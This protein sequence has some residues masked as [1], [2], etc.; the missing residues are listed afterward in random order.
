MWFEM[1][2]V[3]LLMMM[4]LSTSSH[5]QFNSN[6]LLAHKRSCQTYGSYSS[7]NMCYLTYS[8]IFLGIWVINPC[9]KFNRTSM[10]KVI[11]ETN[12]KCS[13]VMLIM[14]RYDYI[15]VIFEDTSA[16]RNQNMINHRKQGV[17]CDWHT[18]SRHQCRETF[19]IILN[20][21]YAL[22]FK[23]SLVCQHHPRQDTSPD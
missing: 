11:L 19:E 14:L 17:L 15:C 13:Y 4:I 5:I 2:K 7:V 23:V 22:W 12:A 10:M 18:H 1:L 20:K 6:L 9:A 3:D 8:N 16:V 21:I